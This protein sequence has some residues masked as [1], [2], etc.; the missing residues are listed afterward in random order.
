[1]ADEDFEIDVYGDA[2]PDSDLKIEDA[3]NQAYDNNTSI[4]IANGST[5]A[6]HENHDAGDSHNHGPHDR[7]EQHTADNH[8]D[9]GGQTRPHQQGVK[10]KG[11]SDDRPVDPGATNCLQI[12][13]LNWW[14]TDDDIRGWVAQASC[15]D[16]LKDITFSEHKVN[17][18]SKGQAYLEFSSQQ[19]AT[20]AKH[21]IEQ[22][23]LEGMGSQPG[24]KKHTVIYSSPSSNPFRTLPKDA[25]GRGKDTPT[26]RGGATSNYN[27]RGGGGFRG[28]G[29]FNGPRGGFNRNFG[30]SNMGGGGGNFGFRGGMMGGN[31]GPAM[32][33][34]G[35]RGG[36]GGMGPG[37]N[38]GVG[39]GM[40]SGMMGG[41]G[42]MGM[43]MMPFQQPH[44]NPAFFAGNQQTDWQNPHGAKRPRGE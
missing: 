5:S 16:E 24:G 4:T 12:S 21:K 26:T 27:D 13:D 36:R 1:M 2:N 40:N 22:A 7:H 29:G 3:N 43:P 34:G 30:G 42:G 9:R 19:A 17:G 37:M 15:E 25:T 14:T 41:M 18:K 35:M 38:P 39:P 23:G 32:R 8:E 28:R 33:G 20:A 6:E 10:R 11:E 31:M 44:F